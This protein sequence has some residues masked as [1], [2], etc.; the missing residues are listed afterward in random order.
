M[1][2]EIYG[3]AGRSCPQWTEMQTLS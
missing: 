1:Q 3:G 2:T